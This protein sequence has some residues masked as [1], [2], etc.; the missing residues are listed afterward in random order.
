MSHIHWING[1]ISISR[2]VPQPFH[3]KS[4]N[5]GIGRE[6]KGASGKEEGHLVQR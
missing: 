1:H 4:H 6:L 5:R 2:R 3:S